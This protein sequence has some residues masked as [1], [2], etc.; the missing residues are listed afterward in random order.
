MLYVAFG[1]QT[2]E[3]TQV[4][5]WFSQFKSGVASDVDDKCSGFLLISK[6]RKFRLSEGTVPRKQKT[7]T[8]Q[9]ANMFG[10]SPG[11]V[12]SILKDKLP[13]MQNSED[14]FLHLNITHAHTDL[15]VHDFLWGKEKRPK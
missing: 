9:A 5:V 2:M 10:I 8:H 11:P 1:D 3:R 15:S 12:Q 14:W 4:F 6:T 7:T 13:E